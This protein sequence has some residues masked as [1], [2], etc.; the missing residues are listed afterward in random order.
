MQRAYVYAIEMA[1]VMLIIV[2]GLVMMGVMR[3]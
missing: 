2:E 1:M 3:L